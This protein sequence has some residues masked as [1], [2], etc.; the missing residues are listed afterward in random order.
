MT[1]GVCFPD[2]S[3]SESDSIDLISKSICEA[4]SNG[5]KGAP[6]FMFGAGA[7][8]SC[9]IPLGYEII[10]RAKTE[11]IRLKRSWKEPAPKKGWSFYEQAM[12]QLPRESQ[13]RLVQEFISDA[14]LRD[15][16]WRL[17]HAYLTLAEIWRNSGEEVIPDQ[18]GKERRFS[19]LPRVLMTTNFDPLFHFALLERNVEEPKLIRHPSEL[20]YMSPFETQVFPTIIHMHGYWQNHYVYQEPK[21]WEQYG[22]R[23]VEPLAM[24]IL[25]YG[26][27]VVGYAGVDDDVFSKIFKKLQNAGQTMFGDVYWCYRHTDGMPIQTYDELR[28]FTNIKFIPISD[29]DSFMRHIGVRLDLDEIK[30]ID[31]FTRMLYPLPPANV[32][33]FENNAQLEINL[34]DKQS[35]LIKITTSE[36]FHKPGENYAGLEIFSVEKIFNLTDFLSIE[37][38]YEAEIVGSAQCPEF[39]TFELKFQG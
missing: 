37:L 39:P 9:G 6:L 13:M 10:P 28:N 3:L 35:L 4:G 30:L 34:D 36:F 17:N 15:G 21:E 16:R 12:S 26:L 29:A 33:V 18:K 23:F 19:K 25:N 31:V 20:A 2:S 11:A 32:Q 14:R 1:T 38:E 7:S 8:Y 27:V 22:G 5:R 24:Q